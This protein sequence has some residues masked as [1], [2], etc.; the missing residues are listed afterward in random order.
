M[1]VK[2]TP[3]KRSDESKPT[4]PSS[5]ME[6]VPTVLVTGFEPFGGNDTNISQRV[7]NRLQ[8]SHQLVNPW[9]AHSFPVHVETDVLAV[10][11]EGAQRTRADQQRR[12]VGCHSPCWSVR[13]MRCSTLGALGARSSPHANP[14]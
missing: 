6:P 7:V 2:M 4:F 9:T 5:V 12:R 10:D 13:I 3:M 8:G 1:F 14:R 11:A